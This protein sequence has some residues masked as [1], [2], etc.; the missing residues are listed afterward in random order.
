MLLPGSLPWQP[1]SQE[2]LAALRQHMKQ[3]Q[4]REGLRWECRPF[5]EPE[6]LPIAPQL[7]CEGEKDLVQ[8]AA[9]D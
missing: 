4:S 9:R 7:G 2:Q 6:S 5:K 8:E 1:V 3:F